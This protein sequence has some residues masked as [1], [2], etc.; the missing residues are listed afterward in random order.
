VPL[1]IER[2][3]LVSHD[4]WRRFVVRRIQIR[5]GIVMRSDRGK[6]RVRITDDMA[7]IALKSAKIGLTRVEFEYPI[8]VV[9][10]EEMLRIMCGDHILRKVRH[11]VA[12]EGAV[13]Q[14]DVYD[15]ILNGIVIAEIE[16]QRE[17]QVL[18]LPDWV[19]A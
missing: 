8:P 2:K 10:A 15:G 5:D 7:T 6:T 14:I 12:C 4:G 19:G 16:L 11:I 18:N 3:F 13:W 1:E 17:D 9:D